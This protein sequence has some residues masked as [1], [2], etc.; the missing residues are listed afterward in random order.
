MIPSL[1]GNV[2]TDKLGT[3]LMHE[4]VF[5]LNAELMINYPELFPEDEMVD[6]AVRTLTE[7]GQSGIDTFVDLSV[8]GTGRNIPV[9]KRIAEQV[10][11]NILVATGWYTY[12]EA[13]AFANLNGPG[14]LFDGPDPLA[15]IFIRD[16]REGI[17]STGVRAAVLKC[18]ADKFG[19]T[20]GVRI[21]MQAVADAHLETGTPIMTH[22]SPAHDTGSLQQDYFESRGIDLASIVIGHVGD[23]DDIDVLRRIAD[24]GSVL[25]MDRFGLESQLPYEQRI[26]TVVRMCELGYADRMV[27]ATDSSVF[28]MNFPDEHRRTNLPL[29]DARVVMPR[30]VTDIRARGVCDSDI[31][32][33]MRINPRRILGV[34][35]NEESVGA[36]ES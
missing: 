23:T 10:D 15:E 18:S 14:R 33:M 34:G 25:G 11:L 3:V 27:L 9:L 30:I 26:D 5:V 28:S 8:M 6:R 29:W 1:T 20:E 36:A 17:S 24:R 12:F 32:Q 7:V 4:H 16:I 13:P 2:P 31:D 19:V 21:I 22:S 35:S